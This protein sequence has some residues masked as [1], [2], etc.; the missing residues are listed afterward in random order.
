M[1][2]EPKDLIR[3][4]EHLQPGETIVRWSSGLCE[5]TM[6]G[7]DTKRNGFVVATDRRVFV[8]VP[9]MFNNFELEEFPFATMSSIEYGKEMLGHSI[10]LIASGNSLKVTMMNQGE[11]QALVEYVRGKIGKKEEPKVQCP[12]CGFSN[13]A[14]WQFCGGCG[15]PKQVAKDGGGDD[16]LAKLE[17][18]ADLHAKGVLNAEEFQQAKAKLLT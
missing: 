13:S 14:E 1:S 18:L 9:K 4:K 7:K 2:T 16:F 10:K 17:R 5:S 11:P 12:Q 15:K 3:A 6:F 8:F